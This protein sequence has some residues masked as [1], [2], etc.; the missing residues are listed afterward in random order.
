MNS[1]LE[2]ERLRGL[3]PEIEVLFV[4]GDHTYAGALADLMNFGPQAKRIFVHD[5]DAPDF[6]GVRTA[7]EKFCEETK[8]KAI[9]HHGSFGMAEIQSQ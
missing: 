8:R 5:T 4:D 7:V 2:S 1:I 3:L 9:Y 6:P